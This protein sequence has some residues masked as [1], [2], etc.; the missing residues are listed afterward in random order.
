MVHDEI[1][2]NHWY[3]TYLLRLTNNGQD[4]PDI[5]FWYCFIALKFWPISEKYDQILKLTKL[6]VTATMNLRSYIMNH[7]SVTCS[8]KH[9]VMFLFISTQ[10]TANH[11]L[12]YTF[13]ST[14]VATTGWTSWNWQKLF[15][16]WW[17]REY[18]HYSPQCKYNCSHHSTSLPFPVNHGS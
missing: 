8:Y 13:P 3:A 16:W 1:L 11:N 12:H 9:D 2:W 7:C 14:T 17:G 5:S 18:Q 15:S 6:H 4:L 10:N